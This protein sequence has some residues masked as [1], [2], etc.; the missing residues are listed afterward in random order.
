[1]RYLVFT[2]VVLSLI[3]GFCLTRQTPS[4]STLNKY[5]Y[6]VNNVSGN[7]LI[8]GTGFPVR[9]ANENYIITAFHLVSSKYGALSVTHEGKT[10]WADVV[11]FDVDKDLLLLETDYPIKETVS[12]SR[13]VPDYPFQKVYS[14]GST[15]QN[16]MIVA[17]GNVGYVDDKN[18][19]SLN[20]PAYPGFSGG[21]AFIAYNGKFY[22][23]GSM[24]RYYTA[25]PTLWEGQNS[26]SILDF[27]KEFQERKYGRY[28]KA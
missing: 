20:I 1:M 25:Y 22:L 15:L 5:Y 26:D 7:L 13:N 11:F 21:G 18:L 24:Q 27:M 28:K 19:M 3:I 17:E 12:I 23:R 4:P 6:R 8:S 16:R 9:I 10:E 14:M 2:Y